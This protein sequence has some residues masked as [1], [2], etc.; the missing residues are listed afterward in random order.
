VEI[1]VVYASQYGN[2]QR[3]AQSLGAALAGDHSVR[4]V[5]AAVAGDLR[6]EGVDLLFVGAPTQMRGSRMLTGAF[7]D[8]LVDRGFQGVPAAA[9]DTRMG[10]PPAAHVASTAIDQR[11]R[12]AGCPIAAPPESFVVTDV[13]GPLAQGELRRAGAWARAVADAVAVGT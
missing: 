5:Q 13:E 4:V 9:F 12:D 2:T 10:D 6:G 3:I 8:E 7:L 1:L 11:L